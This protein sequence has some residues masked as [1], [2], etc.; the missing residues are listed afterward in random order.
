MVRSL[1][2]DALMT[3]EDHAVSASVREG[4]VMLDGDVARPW[5]LD[6]VEAMIW[7][8]PGVIGVENRAVARHPEPH[9]G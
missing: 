7:R 4:V 9:L 1:L 5:D 8:V 6:L 3:P 2:G